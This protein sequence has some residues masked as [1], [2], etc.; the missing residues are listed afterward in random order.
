MAHSSVSDVLTHCCELQDLAPGLNRRQRKAAK[1]AVLRQSDTP[2]DGS[3]CAE[4]SNV[5]ADLK[6][7]DPV[8]SKNSTPEVSSFPPCVCVS[9]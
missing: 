6:E 1:R 9:G 8:L 2:A 3:S 4:H 7:A 5:V